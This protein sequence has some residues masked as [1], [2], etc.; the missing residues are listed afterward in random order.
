MVEPCALLCSLHQWQLPLPTAQ[1]KYKP[2]FIPLNEDKAFWRVWLGWSL[3]AYQRIW[4]CPISTS[5]KVNN[6]E[7]EMFVLKLKVLTYYFAALLK[8]PMTAYTLPTL[9]S[10]RDTISGRSLKLSI[11]SVVLRLS[12]GCQTNVILV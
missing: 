9:S 3:E 8:S 11:I 7:H 10:A 2:N 1:K 4:L 12:Q 6:I 5:K